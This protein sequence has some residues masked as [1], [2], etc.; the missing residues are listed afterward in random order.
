VPYRC[1]FGVSTP[2]PGL[3]LEY[4]GN[5]LGTGY[6][7][8]VAGGPRKRVYW[9]LFI[10]NQE[11]PNTLHETIPRYTEKEMEDTAER[12]R[13]TPVTETISFGALWDNR[14]TAT[15]TALPEFVHSKWHF[16]RVVTIG[17]AAHK[18]NPINGQGGNN[19]IED[20]AV[21]VN[22]LTTFLAAGRSKKTRLS[23]EEVE[24]LFIR[25]QK[26]RLGRVQSFMERGHSLQKLQAQDG[27]RG[28][29][30]AFVLR[31]WA[32]AEFAIN[33]LSGL[34]LSAP[35]VDALPLPDRSHSI[36]FG[37][38]LVCQQSITPHGGLLVSIVL[39]S[40][41]LLGNWAFKNINWPTN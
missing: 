13:N 11:P 1:I 2:L 39:A 20:C 32:S 16:G 26:I 19:A 35:R 4:S 14:T 40:I 29:L 9:F 24:Q 21:L 33:T 25:F 3:D 30:S 5:V 38:E 10:Q 37:D 18:F 7:F 17:D 34:W 22:Q 28:L 12:F 27:L 41:L 6:S 23:D 8:L 31:R 15:L 36:P